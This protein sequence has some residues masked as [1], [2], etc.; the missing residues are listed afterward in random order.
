MCDWTVASPSAGIRTRSHSCA[1]QMA[2]FTCRLQSNPLMGLQHSTHF[3]N[4]QAH[5]DAE[6]PQRPCMRDRAV[7]FSRHSIH[8][9]MS[10]WRF[11]SKTSGATEQNHYSYIFFKSV[12]RKI[13]ASPKPY[14]LP[15]PWVTFFL[16]LFPY[17]P[18]HP[19]SYS[20]IKYSSRWFGFNNSRSWWGELLES[21]HRHR[22]QHLF[23]NG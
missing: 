13:N 14:P 2:A 5:S 16:S 3:G 23:V 22:E 15:M 19:H 12:G 21:K 7:S 18:P 9:K 20:T 1:T 6:T 4:R 11:L 10:I 8:D 17:P